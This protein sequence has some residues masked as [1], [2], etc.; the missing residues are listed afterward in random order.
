M[1]YIRNISSNTFRD[2]E[3]YKFLLK[4]QWNTTYTTCDVVSFKAFSLN[5]YEMWLF[6]TVL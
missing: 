6:D 5:L 4:F 1:L 3:I 2:P